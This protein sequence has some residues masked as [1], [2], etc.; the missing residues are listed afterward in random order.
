MDIFESNI[1]ISNSI[2]R[3][4]ADYVEYYDGHGGAIYSDNS[5]LTINNSVIH[6]NKATYSY[7]ET[8]SYGG[9]IYANNAPKKT[10][11]SNVLFYNNSSYKGGG[12]YANDAI[13]TNCTF[14]NNSASYGEAI[15][16][17]RDTITN[18]IF[19]NNDMWLSNNSSVSY[20]CT[21]YP[22]GQG[23]INE[24]PQLIDP[25]NINFRLSPSSPCIDAGDPDTA[26]FT[27]PSYDLDFHPRIINDRI[28]MGVYEYQSTTPQN[29]QTSPSGFDF[30]HCSVSMFKIDTLIV[31][32]TGT[33]LLSVD[34]ITL[35]EGYQIKLENGDYSSV[36][37]Y[38][39]V[40]GISS[41]RFIIR[42]LPEE[43]VEYNGFIY[44]YSNDPDEP[45]LS[46]SVTGIG[47]LAINEI[48]LEAIVISPNPT[49]ELVKI[50]VSY[51]FTRLELFD[52][53]GNTIKDINIK[54][55]KMILLNT[56]DL[57]KGLYILRL[58]DEYY[59]INRKLII[60]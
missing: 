54:Q 21:T 4:N 14:A 49:S 26:N 47:D 10:L 1:N 24:D 44:I 59:I 40:P 46:L 53:Q 27:V 36:I 25:E 9:G 15:G 30:G 57:P 39:E 45:V 52:T 43:S 31:Y 11:I 51:P 5:T 28:D 22:S 32:N 18:S 3:F 34:S 58:K 56:S 20:S 6:D 13:F 50:T 41:K 48:S 33:D 37:Y 8:S 42:F 7:Y 55:Q 12:A 17:K 35:P 19:Y 23:N 38:V 29:I 60:Y 2:F 16:G